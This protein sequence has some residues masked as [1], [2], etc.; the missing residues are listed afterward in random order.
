MSN[1]SPPGLPFK[2]TLI[3]VAKDAYSY[4]TDG[5]S[6]KDPTVVEV[7]RR[8]DVQGALDAAGESFGNRIK[9]FLKRMDAMCRRV[10]EIGDA[11]SWYVSGPVCW[12]RGGLERSLNTHRHSGGSV[13]EARRSKVVLR[14]RVAFMLYIGYYLFS[15]RLACRMFGRWMRFRPRSAAI[16]SPFCR[17]HW[18]F[19]V[20]H[21]A[22]VHMREPTRSRI[23]SVTTTTPISLKCLCSSVPP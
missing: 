20:R 4:N 23:L 6:A 15:F 14:Q 8:I 21:G 5:H 3:Y 9:E 12:T 10:P 19:G 11:V 7:E 2:R 17:R 22:P 18:W 13:G 1:V 16:I